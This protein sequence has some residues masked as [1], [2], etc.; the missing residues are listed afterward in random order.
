MLTTLIVPLLLQ[1]GPNPA[2]S[3]PPAVP[4][5][6]VEQRRIR[7]ERQPAPLAIVGT[8]PVQACAARA[9]A[10]PTGA[11][12]T[13]RSALARSSG[14]DR[15][16]AGHCLALALS[17]QEL[18][19][20]AASALAGA[21]AALPDGNGE[22]AARLSLAEAASW[23]AVGDA[24]AALQVL[25]TA[26]V[27]QGSPLA[28]M[29]AVDRSRALVALGRLDEAAAALAQARLANPDNDEAWLLSA[30]LSRRMGQL[31]LAQQQI[32]RAAILRPA[33][34]E[35]ALEAGVIA[36]LAGRDEAALRSW[37]SVLESAPGTP[38]ALTA[39]DYIAQLRGQ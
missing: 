35:I 11:A 23:L 34:P 24:E 17:A 26:G 12:D 1:V 2:L 20:E 25:D 9:E 39:A 8:D 18:W 4:E 14:M 13:A 32:E 10:D 3:P 15:A 38:A 7:R 21:R 16:T 6:L 30:T 29:I 31:D 28:S 37:Q 19:P 27:E 36:V 33:G 22:Y 5:E